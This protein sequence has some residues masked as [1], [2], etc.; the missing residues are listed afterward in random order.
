MYIYALRRFRQPVVCMLFC[1]SVVLTQAAPMLPDLPAENHDSL[2]TIWS[3]QDIP[4]YLLLRGHKAEETGNALSARAD[5][6]D[7]LDRYPFHPH[8]TYIHYR[9]GRSYAGLGNWQAA[10]DHLLPILS[11]DNSNLLSTKAATALCELYRRLTPEE[12]RQLLELLPANL[13]NRCRTEADAARGTLLILPLSGA[14]EEQGR[15]LMRSIRIGQEL[16]AVSGDKLRLLDNQSDPLVH[17]RI[18]GELAPDRDWTVFQTDT[19]A[20]LAPLQLLP[21]IHTICPDRSL[22]ATEVLPTISLHLDPLLQAR[23]LA[24]WAWDTLGLRSFAILAP[25]DTIGRSMARE[26]SRIVESKGDTVLFSGYFFPGSDDI[27]K[28]LQELRQFGL[29]LDFR[30][31]LRWSYADTIQAMKSDMELL[32]WSNSDTLRIMDAF[33]LPTGDWYHEQELLFPPD[34]AGLQAVCHV[35]ARND[36]VYQVTPADS[37]PLPPEV[38][39]YLFEA[40]ERSHPSKNSPVHS[41]DAIFFPLNGEDVRHMATQVAYYHFDTQL[42]GSEFWVDWATRKEA[43]SLMKGMIAPLPF[44]PGEQV[45]RFVTEFYNSTYRYPALEQLIASATPQLLTTLTGR[46]ALRAACDTTGVN[47]DSSFVFNPG[48]RLAE[49]LNQTPRLGWFDGRSWHLLGKQAP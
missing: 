6:I 30:D 38:L 42:L 40:Y 48:M 36:T 17:A 16:T 5:W 15:D 41:I 35:F 12:G 22:P 9:L 47:L 28:Q 23:T 29:E 8:T 37:L 7:F 34:S 14:D 2:L 49:G 43:G 20:M 11:S 13:D 32:D 19:E 1:L 21:R 33:G 18:L 25:A 24:T 44:L 39:P 31:S 26:F 3:G 4:E 10:T 45:E 27:G 46:E